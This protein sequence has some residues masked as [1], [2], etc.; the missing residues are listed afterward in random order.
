MVNQK[1]NSTGTHNNRMKKPL[2]TLL[3]ALLTCF[4]QWEIRVILDDGG[5]WLR[6][7]V[8][9]RTSCTRASWQWFT[10]RAFHYT[11]TRP[12]RKI[13]ESLSLKKR[14]PWKSYSQIS[15]PRW[16]LTFLLFDFLLYQKRLE[17]KFK[18]FRDFGLQLVILLA[19]PLES[20]WRRD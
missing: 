1:L 5:R 2:K 9:M 8:R 17:K 20:A 13:Y 14:Q 4:P 15:I 11:S 19:L 16:V 10:R 12:K 18:N 7:F 3:S 6:N